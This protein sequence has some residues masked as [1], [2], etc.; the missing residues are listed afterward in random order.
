MIE[1]AGQ[2]LSLTGASV[3]VV[4]QPLPSDDPKQ[5]RPDITLA[6]ARLGWEPRVELAEG[7]AY[8]ISYFRSLAPVD[9]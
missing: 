7:L 6:K 9:G 8:T 3:K 5:R 2:V 1:L 4:H